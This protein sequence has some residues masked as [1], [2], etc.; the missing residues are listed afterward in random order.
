MLT[1]SFHVFRKD[2]LF[3]NNPGWSL[4]PFFLTPR[5]DDNAASSP[6]SSG[7]SSSDD[8]VVVGDDDE[9]VD[10]ATSS[11]HHDIFGESFD[12]F[13][14]QDSGLGHHRDANSHS[15]KE[16]SNDLQKVGLSD[17]LSLFQLEDR[18]PDP[19]STKSA[20]AVGTSGRDSFGEDN[21]FDN[22]FDSTFGG[23]MEP[24]EGSNSDMLERVVVF[25]GSADLGGHE[26]LVGSDVPGPYLE[27]H[28]HEASQG[29]EVVETLFG[30]PV[31]LVGVEAAGTAKAMEKALKEGIV[32][33]AGPI[34]PHAD[35]VL[36]KDD[37]STVRDGVGNAD[38]NDVNYWRS[39][40]DQSVAQDEQL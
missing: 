16:L 13:G 32:G 1:A 5:G 19:F 4:T 14:D 23:S 20:D 6:N 29:P 25:D 35:A 30:S 40:Y 10:T 34:L 8:E 11:S 36:D 33:E 28:K 31:K 12:A 24:V 21:P 27:N 18:S 3:G 17:S 26:S 15:V 37:E 7:G 22:P 39:D 9:L 2:N 38:Y